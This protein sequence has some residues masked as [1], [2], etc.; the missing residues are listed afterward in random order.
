NLT[1]DQYQQA[2]DDIVGQG[3]RLTWVSGYSV[4]GEDRFAA[5]WEQDDGGSAFQAR[6]NLTGSEYQQAFDQLVGQGFRLRV[7]DGHDSQA[8]FTLSHFTFADDIS[9]ENRARLIDR[10][11][12][13]LARVGTCGNLSGAEKDSLSETYGRQ[14]HHTTLNKAGVNASA[15]VGGSQLNVNFGVLFPQGDE[16]ISQTLIHEMMHCAGFT[17][18]DRRDPP[19][20][21]D[22]GTPDPAVFDCPND[23][24]QYYGTAPLRAEFCI[25]GDQS[26][27]Q[28]RLA[29]KADDESCIIDEQG[30]AT[31]ERR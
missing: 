15:Q 19:P 30:E 5:I 10:H 20:G 23:N 6:H 3:F 31:I 13:A 24:G 16:E 22:C 1:A 9:E 29:Q 2:F 7:V 4:N 21:S 18:P 17:H 26:D 14:I 11:R 27:V 28:S 8:F 12:F 25:A